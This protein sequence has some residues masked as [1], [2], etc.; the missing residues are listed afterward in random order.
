M[1]R[2]PHHH[3]LCRAGGAILGVTVGC[4]VAVGYLFVLFQRAYRN[5]G[6]GDPSQSVGSYRSIARELLCIAIPITI[7]SA[8]L[9]IL[10]MMEVKVYMTQLLAIGFTQDM[11]D[12]MKG[13]YNMTQTIYNLPCAFITPLT[14]SAI[15]AITSALTLKQFDHVRRTEESASRITG[16]IC[17]PCAVGLL[18]LAEP[19]MALLGG[20]QG[21]ELALASTL[22]RVLSVCVVFSSTV[23]MPCA[24]G[25]LVLAEPIMALLGGY[26]GEELALASTLMR[27]LSVCVVFSS[28]VM[29]TNT[30]MQA[31][32]HVNLPVVNMF[33][34]G[35]LKLTMV[36][37]LSGNPRIHI[38]GAPIAWVCCF[39]Q[40]HGHVNLPVVNMFVGGVLKLTMVYFLSGNPRIHIIGA[41]IAWVCCFV[42]ITALNLFAMAKA[43]PHPPRMVRNM[44]KPFIG[45]LVMGAVVYAVYYGLSL[46]LPLTTTLGKLVCSAAPIAA[47]AAVYAVCVVK[48]KAITREDCMLLPK[49]ERIAKFLHLDG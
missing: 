6:P 17:M 15:P 45:A 32:G 39:M 8:G 31:H 38:I 43:I 2:H 1:H 44:C 21:E 4:L 48:L 25:L 22:M 34:G 5:L 47:A 41:P 14:V 10:T 3:W 18:V 27:V 33:V 11:A 9:Q 37:F 16:L 13:I 40:A 24:V 19:I 28:T 12:S 23:M 42:C 49:G 30:I 46:L 7:G 26:Q 29:L 20:Y 35:V 36:Y